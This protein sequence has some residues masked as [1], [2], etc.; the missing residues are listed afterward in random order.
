MYTDLKLFIDGQW[1]NGEGRKGED[2]VNPAT[3]KVLAKLPH[4]SKADLDDALA[5]AEKGF[6]VWKATSAYDRAK[7]MRKAADLLRERAEHIADGADAG[8]GQGLRRVAHR[9]ADL[10]RHHR[11]VRRGRPP[12]LW[13]HRAGP[14]EGRAPDRGAGAGRR[15]RRVH[16]VEF[17]DADAGAQDRRC[18]RRRLLDHHQ[19]LGRNA[20]RLRRTGQVLRRCR[21]AGGRAQSRVRRSGG[22][23]GAPDRR[24]TSSRR[25]RSPARSRSASISPASPPRA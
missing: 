12:R 22:S 14:H 17:P 18:A 4:A 11:L 21:R 24:P 7:I 23:V 15:R 5:A 10:R 9:S 8:A 3:G 20:R 25:S 19:G 16:A 2:V 6:K 1:L 13:P